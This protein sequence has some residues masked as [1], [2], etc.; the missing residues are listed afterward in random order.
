MVLRFES[1]L[2]LS[3]YSKY[4]PLFALYL[5]TSRAAFEGLKHLGLTE[6]FRALNPLGQGEYS[7]WDYQAG[8]WQKDNGIRID[9]FLLSAY[10]ADRLESC[11]INKTPRGWDSASDHTPI[12]LDLNISA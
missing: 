3:G 2:K 4:L 5:P 6:S 1:K 8:A 12:E 7:F 10:Y 9:H 11:R